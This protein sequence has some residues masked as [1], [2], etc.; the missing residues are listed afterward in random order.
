VIVTLRLG[1]GE[2]E[3]IET[4][5]WDESGIARLSSTAPGSPSPCAYNPPVVL[6]RFPLAVVTLPTQTWSGPGCSG[7]LEVTVSGEE[8]VKDAVGRIWRAWR[9]QRV[10]R[11][12]DGT[13]KLQV[14]SWFAPQIGI[15]V[16]AERVYE[17]I[18]GA[19]RTSIR[20][21]IALVS[22]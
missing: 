15:E 16:L 17:R 14:V 7:S 13:E 22:P 10:H 1:E 18:D 11:E 6:V 20:Q 8:S 9:I 2:N 19:R 5:R 3:S 4:Q 12:A 21:G